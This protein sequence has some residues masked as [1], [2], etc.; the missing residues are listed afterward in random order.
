MTSLTLVELRR[1]AARKIPLFCLVLLLAAVGVSLYGLSQN[2]QNIATVREMAQRDLALERANWE[3]EQESFNEFKEQCLADQQAERDRSGDQSIDFG[4]VW[5]EPTVEGIMERYEA[6]SLAQSHHSGL[7]GIG[8]LVLLMALIGGSTSTAAELSHRT[9]GT[10]LTFEPRRDRVFW[11]KLA[12]AGVAFVPIAIA[13]AALIMAGTAAV[14]QIRGVDAAVTATEW[15]ELGWMAV[16]LVA[17]AAFLG[18]V[19]AAAGLL[20]RHTGAV[21][22]LAAGYLLVVEQMVIGLF[23]QWQRFLLTP[24]F[25]AWIEDGTILY[26]NTCETD[27]M[28]NMNCFQTE[29][30]LSLEH[31]ALVI[32]I[33]GLVIVLV[34]WLLFRRR[35]VN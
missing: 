34:S 21:L 7:L 33:V 2:V 19:G 17:L 1:L 25:R 35:D 9:M 22:G 6:P 15:S 14:Y 13:G 20:L 29:V 10:W 31:G 32:G 24:N 28:G 8:S 3:A 11:S 23:P 27:D 4:C 12:A 18:L 30:P 5:E 16:R 26:E